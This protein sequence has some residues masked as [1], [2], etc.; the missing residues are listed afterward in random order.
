M[1]LEN[2]QLAVKTIY[3]THETLD[4]TLALIQKYNISGSEIFDAYL[5]ATVMSNDC[6][7]IATDN[8]KHL[9]KY[10]EFTE[11]TVINPFK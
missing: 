10:T 7:V 5:V 9:K 3:P 11:F 6:F 4:I 1:A 2:I 8:E